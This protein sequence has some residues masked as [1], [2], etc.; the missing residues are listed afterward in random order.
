MSEIQGKPVYGVCECNEKKQVLSIDQVTDLIQQM[1]ANGWQV[2]AD[3]I[4]KTSVNGIIEQHEGRELKLWIGTQAKWDEWAGDKNNVYAII[5]DDPTLATIN[6]ILNEHGQSIENINSILNNH[7]T[8]LNSHTQS[9]NSIEERLTRLGVRE[10]VATFSSDALEYLESSSYIKLYRQ[11]NYVILKGKLDFKKGDDSNDYNREASVMGKFF[12]SNYINMN[13][14]DFFT[15]PNDFLPL[16]E[17]NFFIG[18]SFVTYIL[19]QTTYSTANVALSVLCSYNNNG[20]VIRKPHCDNL[21]LAQTMQPQYDTYANYN[22]LEFSVGYEA[23]P[24]E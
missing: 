7:N 2:P 21:G 12:E 8:Q 3:Y 6:K 23:A 13:G 4:P 11:G 20:V 5:T 22:S 1:A 15:I 24:I 14:V 17:F 19:H 18:C 10:G 16:T 9:I